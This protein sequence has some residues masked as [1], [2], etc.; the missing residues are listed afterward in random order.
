M[1][2]TLDA[3]NAMDFDEFIETFG[4]II[5]HSALVTAAL[6]TKRPF[7]SLQHVLNDVAEIVDTLPTEGR[8]NCEM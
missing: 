8:S 2:I 7:V 1:P 3:M 5:E 4:N 6:W